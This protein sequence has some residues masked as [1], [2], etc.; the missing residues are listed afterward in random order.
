VPRVDGDPVDLQPA[1]VF[2]SPFMNSV[3]GSGVVTIQK[4][5]RKL[6]LD[7]SQTEQE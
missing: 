7:F 6:V 3:H 4:G 5:D 2:D 1:K